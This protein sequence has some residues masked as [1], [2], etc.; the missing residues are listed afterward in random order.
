MLKENVAR[1][2]N[3]F[4]FEDGSL[5]RNQA[6]FEGLFAKGGLTLVRTFEE[7]GFPKELVPVKSFVLK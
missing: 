7:S 5:I 4:D 3:F 1:G 2:E 6:Q